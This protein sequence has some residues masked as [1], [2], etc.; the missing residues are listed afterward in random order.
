MTASNQISQFF[1]SHF[2]FTPNSGQKS[3]LNALAGFV[4]PENTS[5][6]FILT[7]PAGSG[8]TSLLRS[9]IEWFD[10]NETFYSLAAP[11]GRA[12][13][14]AGKRTQAHATTLHS[15]LFKVQVQDNPLQV[16]FIPRINTPH[17]DVRYFII[18]ESS[19]ISDKTNVEGM[20]HQNISLLSQLFRFARQG[21][22]LNKI[23][24]I[25]DVFQLP[26]V[27][28]DFSPAL[29]PEYLKEKFNVSLQ[30]SNLDIVERNTAD[31]YILE[32]AKQILD[33]MNTRQENMRLSY[34]HTAGFSAGIKQ[35]LSDASADPM[36]NSVMIA[37]A[38]SQV[39][40]LN[41]W[42]R[43]FRYNYKE[44]SSV[45]PD[46]VMICNNNTEIDEHLLYK[47]NP[48]MVKKTWKQEEFA[49]MNFINAEIEFDNLYN[50]RVY[51]KTKILID[52]VNSHDGA[53]PY[54][55]EKRLLHEAYKFNRKFR[56]SKRPSDDAFVSALR[57]RYGYALTCHKA[58]GGEWNSVYLHPGYR[59]ED[60][61]WLYTA[62]TRAVQD[63]Y[64][65]KN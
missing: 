14:I 54:E 43:K 39:N 7:G 44:N 17:E 34:A 18:D 65:W 1:F 59:K 36:Y 2:G 28:S 55:N 58:Q 3:A 38:N 51:A 48:F 31:S 20:F 62:V 42:A 33:S 23:I 37:L 27:N 6:C 25:G 11:T 9:L 64:T 57:A 52:S 46:E 47:G 24:F 53:I 30:C 4:A 60:L 56:E 15:L 45:M 13:Q 61:R 19:M 26:P 21:N 5:T 50:V 22:A 63:L 16:N 35:Y 32:N 10:K 12:A 29:S 40:A 49:G 41:T 8:K